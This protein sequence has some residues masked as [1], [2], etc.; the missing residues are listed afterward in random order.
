MGNRTASQSSSRDQ[1]RILW[2]AISLMIAVSI[3]VLSITLWVLYRENFDQRVQDLRAMILGQVSLIEAVAR[4]DQQNAGLQFRGGSSQATLG[5][6]ID[7]FTQLGGFSETGEFVVGRRKGNQIEFLTNFRFPGDGVRRTVPLDTQRAAPMRRALNNESGWMIGL[8]YRGQEVLAA[9]E[10]IGDLDVGLVAKVDMREVRA[11]FFRAA[12]AALG[13]AALAIIIGGFLMLRMARPV[14]QRIEEVQ[15]RFRKLLE[16]APDAMVVIDNTG[17]IVM[18]N[19]QAQLMFGCSRDELIGSPIEELIPKRYRGDHP[20]K[21]RSYFLNPSTRPMGAGLELHGLTRDG[22]E[23]PVEISLS[24]IETEEGMLVA[25]SLRDVTERKEAEAALKALKEDAERQRRI[26]MALN[27]LSDVLRGQQEMSGLANVIVH[28]LASHLGLQYAGVFALRDDGVFVREAAYGYSKEGGVRRFEIGDGLLG[29][30]A[31]DGRPVTVDQVPEYA[32]L[33]LGLG[34]IPLAH[35]LIYPLIHDGVVVGVLELGGLNPLDEDRQNWLEK[36]RDGL[37]MTIRLVLDLEERNRVA[38]ELAR[39]KEA[40]EHANAAK[41]SFLANM[42]HELR[43]PMNAILGYSEM[44]MEEAEDIGQ[45]DFIPDLKKINQAGSHLLALINDVLDLSKIESGRMESFAENIV[46]DSLIDQV[47]GT[48]QPLMAKNKNQLTIERVGELGSVRQDMTKLRQALL[49]LLSNAAKF[50]HEGTVTLRAERAHAGGGEWL[51]LA[52]SDTGIGI[53]ED[54]LEHVFEEFSQA[55]ASTTREYGGTGLGLTISRRFC[56][57]LGGDL[58]VAS[59]AGEGST[60]T[61]RVP[62]QL[63]GADAE[64]PVE[65]APVTTEAQLEAIAVT[66]AGRTVLVIDDD[67]ESR[68]IVE[69]FLRKDGFEVATAGGGEEGLRLAHK[70]R[71]AAITLDVMMPDMDGWSVLRALKADPVLRD[72]PVVMLTMV[73]DKG[74]GYSLGATDYLTKPVDR[75]QLHAALARYHISGEPG[76]VLLVEDDRPTREMVA[77]A[78][79]KAGWQ[80]SQAGNGREALDRM[81]QEKPG[82]ILLDLM[83]PVMDGFDFLLEMRAQPEWQD[84]PVIVLTAK[85]L[86]D[87]DRRILSGRVEQIVAKGA[88]SNEQVV[89]MIHQVLDHGAPRTG[90]TPGAAI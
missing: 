3:F 61:I 42:S 76:R 27:E 12:G 36:A 58:T 8:D 90:K 48:T 41:S 88:G 17:E 45:D 6:V 59:R 29:Q 83:M 5:Q 47:V 37:A 75:A 23:F 35:L 43:T 44:L 15:R 7:G 63:E 28:Q 70:L 79:S 14:L 74:K 73:D 67:P 13:I 25:S 1:S 55:D 65:V 18:V 32:Q 66:G 54:K 26:E 33:A 40:A 60:F 11:P 64:A 87:E 77:R 9:Y 69:H 24:P 71:P 78:L 52:V 89:K 39:A 21:V 56:Q 80:V 86:T 53:P 20:A 51:V 57:M 82:L 62:V 34:K 19:H 85:D 72:V 46:V 68:E 31:L 38:Q 30:A 16:S 84:I 50:T 2:M 4:F 49:N 81:A 22:R 10:P